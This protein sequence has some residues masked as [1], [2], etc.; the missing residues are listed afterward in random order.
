MPLSN[1]SSLL[2]RTS[3]SPG[4]RTAASNASGASQQQQQQQQQQHGRVYL[5]T[6]STDGIGKHTATKLAQAG[7]TVLV[8]GRSKER[9]E[10]TVASLRQAAGDGSSSSV[11]GYTA[12]LSSLAGVRQLAAAVRADHPRLYALV[13][14]A[15][16]Y[17]TQ[18]R[19][20]A[21]GFEATWA[22]NVLAPFLLTSLLWQ[23]V[24]GCI[25]NTASISAASSIDMANLQQERGYS[26]HD[27]YATSKLCNIV[28]TLKLADFLKQRGSPVTVNALDPGTVNTKMLL[29]GWG[30]I[31]I[32]VTSADNTYRLATDPALAGV[33]GGYFVSHRKSRWAAACVC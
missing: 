4:V 6:G 8:H 27:A 25:I 19:L 12:D 17:E 14:N 20:S 31:G 30:R 10:R 13:N 1:S 29:A 15:G 16:V 18:Q 11:Q 33:T 22:V 23:S 24:E 32:D 5:I 2:A 21:D 26:A 28:F 9:V 7:A 3:G